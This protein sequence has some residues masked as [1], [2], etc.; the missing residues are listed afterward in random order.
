MEMK[1]PRI[2]DMR[3]I[4]GTVELWTL[5]GNKFGLDYDQLEIIIPTVFG[6]L[7]GIIIILI[8]F[9]WNK[10]RKN[11]QSFIYS[12]FLTTTILGSLLTF[13][14]TEEQY[15]A[16]YRDCSENIIDTYESVGKY[17]NDIIPSVQKCGGTVPPD[18]YCSVI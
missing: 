11:S 17:L 18:K 13:V 3:F 14:C 1:V 10:I 16:S 6:F 4:P 7:A 12:S 15:S 8:T 9:L 2:K 5:L